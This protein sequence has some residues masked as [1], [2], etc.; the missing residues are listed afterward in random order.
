[1]NEFPSPCVVSKMGIEAD[2]SDICQG[3]PAYD[4]KSEGFSRGNRKTVAVTT[5]RARG[6]GFNDIR[7]LI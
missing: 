2:H 5:T 4:H 3:S 7:I 1:M 6:T